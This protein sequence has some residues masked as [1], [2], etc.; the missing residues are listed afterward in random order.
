MKYKQEMEHVLAELHNIIG[1]HNSEVRWRMVANL[2]QHTIE[3]L[4]DEIGNQKYPDPITEAFGELC[5]ELGDDLEYYNAND[6]IKRKNLNLYFGDDKL[7]ELVKGYIERLEKLLKG[8]V[9]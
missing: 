7:E 2:I 8:E 6:A 9:V 4:P 1:E 5:W 3:D